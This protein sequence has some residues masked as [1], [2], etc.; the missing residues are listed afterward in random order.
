ME[1]YSQTAKCLYCGKEF[2]KSTSRHKYCSSRCKEAFRIQQL[3]LHEGFCKGCGAPITFKIKAGKPTR[4]YCSFSCQLKHTVPTKVL[5]CVD[6]GKQFEF[7]GRTTR[8]RCDACLRLHRNELA[9]QHTQLKKQEAAKFGVASADYYKYRKHVITGDDKCSVCGYNLHQEA[10][11]VHHIDGNHYNSQPSNL[12]ILC[13]N[14]HL[15]LHKRQRTLAKA[16]EVD[17]TKLYQDMKEAEVK[18]RNQA[19][20]PDMVTRTEGSEESESGATHSDTSSVD[21]SHHEAAP[22]TDSWDVQPALG[23]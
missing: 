21:M 2:T 13:A 22:E 16:G 4:V 20:K 1:E 9:S 17:M 15:R 18:E 19:G 7:V 3:E 11:V 12:A 14:C 23:F 10:L 5:T 8:Q 6:C